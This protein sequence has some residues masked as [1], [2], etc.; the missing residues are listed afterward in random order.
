VLFLLVFNGDIGGFWIL[1]FRV[2]ETSE[3]K[4]S[5]DIG[6]DAWNGHCYSEKKKKRL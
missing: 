1:L 6:M 5:S 4:M 3:T 2:G